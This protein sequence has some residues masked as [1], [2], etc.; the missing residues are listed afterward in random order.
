M[1]ANKTII[2]SSEMP[3]ALG[4]YS[5]AARVGD[6][7]FVS[8]QAG[9]SPDTGAVAGSDFE[10]QARQAFEIA[11]DQVKDSAD[12]VNAV[13]IVITGLNRARVLGQERDDFVESSPERVEYQIA[14]RIDV[15]N[16]PL[17]EL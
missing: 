2:A 10:A 12:P 4:P 9:L 16:V 14:N 3:P 6:L 8:G 5:Q 13:P 11:K 17:P 7:L 15:A 1:P